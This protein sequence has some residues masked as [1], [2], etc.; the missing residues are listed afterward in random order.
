MTEKEE[1]PPKTPQP[2]GPLA[3]G[4]TLP[5]RIE[6]WDAATGEKVER[7]LARALSAALARAIFQAALAE[8]PERR[9]T[10]RRGWRLMVDSRRPWQ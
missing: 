6:L 5:Y 9:I 8:H 3:P 2:D 10:L 1:N 7:V 4:E